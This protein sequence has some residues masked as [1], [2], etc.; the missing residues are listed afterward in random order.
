M[1]TH[2][3][4]LYDISLSLSLSICIYIYMM[5][6]CI[7]SIC[8][9]AAGPRARGMTKRKASPGGMSLVLCVMRHCDYK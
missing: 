4:I 6:K 1:Y 3:I 9:V 7:M 2:Y 8:I 5:Y